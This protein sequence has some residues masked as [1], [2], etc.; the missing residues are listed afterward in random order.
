MADKYQAPPEEFVICDFGNWNL[1]VI[2]D[3]LFGI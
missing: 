2:W 3:L 1:F